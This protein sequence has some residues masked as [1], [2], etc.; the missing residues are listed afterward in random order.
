MHFCCRQMHYS[1][2]APVTAGRFLP[3]FSGRTRREILRFN[4]V[5]KGLKALKGTY[6]FSTKSCVF[7][8]DSCWFRWSGILILTLLCTA[9]L[10]INVPVYIYRRTPST[11]SENPTEGSFYCI[12]SSEAVC[13]RGSR[14]GWKVEQQRHKGQKWRKR[15]S[16]QRQHKR[17]AK[18]VRRRS[19]LVAG[20]RVMRRVP[21]FRP[22]VAPSSEPFVAKW[23]V[24]SA[25]RILYRS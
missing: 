25:K 8:V 12:F 13:R 18:I 11:L 23:A 20:S 17:L 3:F 1:T 7:L 21:P 5:T 9:I 15:R 16:E 22:V 14:S 19:F 24:T 10:Y 2:D 6:G 4:W